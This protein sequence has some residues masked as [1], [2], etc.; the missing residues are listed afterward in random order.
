MSTCTTCS[1]NGIVH[2]NK[3]MCAACYHAYRKKQW[4]LSHA[5]RCEDPLYRHNFL[6]KKRL[7]YMPKAYVY[8]NCTQCGATALKASINILCGPCAEKDSAYKKIQYQIKRKKNHLPTRIREALKTRLSKS[9]KNGNK[10]NSIIKYLGCSVEDFK[11][12]LESKF[13]PGMS[14]DNHGFYGWHIDHIRPLCSFNL[15][16]EEEVMAALHYT[17]LQPLWAKDN[18]K[19]GGKYE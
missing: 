18:L 8:K 19:K 2:K 16:N 17:N 1:I 3:K 9:I 5:R 12:Y 15:E 4:D 13:Q 7:K 6:K 11:E 10:K 14:W